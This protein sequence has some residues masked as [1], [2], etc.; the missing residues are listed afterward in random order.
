MK[1][2][3]LFAFAGLWERWTVREGMAL[4]GSL[5]GLA[6]GDAVETCTILTTAANE[7]VAT[8]HHRIPVILPPE[9]FAPWLAGE[10][11]AL[12]P[13]PAEAMSVQPV[14]T[15]VNTPSNDEPR[16]IDPVTLA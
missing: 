14:G 15:L 16:C 11:V 10:A 3:A 7:A 6:P 9:R 12:D 5:A 8:L 13:C 2:G 1:D 4:T